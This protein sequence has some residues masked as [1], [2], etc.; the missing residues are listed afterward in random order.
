MTILDES[1][2]HVFNDP[3]AFMKFSKKAPCICLTATCAESNEGGLERQVLENMQ[4]KIFENLVADQP[5]I[6]NYPEFEK[7][8]I[9]TH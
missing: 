6:P 5:I 2:E 4:F 9:S 8:A 1:D 7:V 3:G